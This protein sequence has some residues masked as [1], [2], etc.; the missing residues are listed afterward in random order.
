M[1][2]KI[3]LYGSDTRDKS[4]NEP[5]KQ[6][7]QQEEI[8]GCAIVVGASSCHV[9]WGV[10]QQYDYISAACAREYYVVNFYGCSL[11]FCLYCFDCDVCG[12]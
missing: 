9:L 1:H 3:I 8:I 4:G 2:N 11:S 5:R 10:L 7:I 6:R 12:G